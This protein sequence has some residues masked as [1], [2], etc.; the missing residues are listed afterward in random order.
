M[1][2]MKMQAA[3]EEDR[4][5]AGHALRIMYYSAERGWH[6][7]GISINNPD[8]FQQ[9]VADQFEQPGR[10]RLVSLIVEMEFYPVTKLKA[11]V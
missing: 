3:E 8:D 5:W 10:Y 11:K 6:D 7:L 1:Q 2:P 4:N 9:L